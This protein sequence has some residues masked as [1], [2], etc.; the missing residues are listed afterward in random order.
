MFSGFC[1]L[2]RNTFLIPIFFFNLLILPSVL[3]VSFFIVQF[4]DP[5]EIY[6]DVTGK[7]EFRFWGFFSPAKSR[8]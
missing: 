8:F 5:S 7:E 3:T 2:L 4:F 6:I 1:V